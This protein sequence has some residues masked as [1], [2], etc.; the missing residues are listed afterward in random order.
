M[1]FSF[2]KRSEFSK[3]LYGFVQPYSRRIISSNRDS[4]NT[5]NNTGK[6]SAASRV[7]AYARQA[8]RKRVAVERRRS[9]RG[10]VWK[11]RRT[12]EDDV[13]APRAEES[14]GRGTSLLAFTARVRLSR[15][16]TPHCTDTLDEFRRTRPAESE[17]GPLVPPAHNG[18]H[19]LPLSPSASF[20][21]VLLC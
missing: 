21:V 3:I 19:G 1:K 16:D 9:W 4:D 8:L 15:W 10:G 14:D 18:R 13:P 12:G 5:R 2:K 11:W 17:G 20:D 7:T 6:E